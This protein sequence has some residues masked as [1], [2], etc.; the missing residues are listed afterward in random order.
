M[1]TYAEALATV[2]KGVSPLAPR[3]MPAVEAAG[4]VLAQEVVADEDMPAFDRT[5][6]DGYAVRSAD[7]SGRGAQLRCIGEVRTGG[8]ALDRRLESGECAA[9]YTGAPIPPGADAVVMVERTK[10]EGDRVTLEVAVR[11]GE[12]VRFRGEDVKRGERLL[13]SDALLRPQ[14][15]A[16]CTSFGVPTPTVRPRPRVAVLSTGDELVSP[17]AKPGPGQI[18]DS[19]GAMLAT[20]AARAGGEVVSFEV[21]RDERDA[22]R[23]ALDAAAARADVLVLSGGVSMGAYDLVPPVLA[24][25]GFSG[26]FHKV[27]VKPGKPVWFGSRGAVCA[28]GLPGNPVSSFVVFEILV[29]PALR[30]MLGWE[31]GPCF[32]RATVVD[33]PVKGGDREQF[34]PARVEREALSFLPWTSSG[35][36]VELARANALARVPIDVTPRPGETVEFLAI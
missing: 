34:V 14:E 18:R 4:L 15:I 13:A 11:A 9:I 36:L 22:I 3:A 6:M 8:P 30:R 17:D 1:L 24:E 12:N 19:N 25:L 7:A 10:V 16:V 31:P 26:G 28:F 21:V 20:Q 2:L 35:D 5:A 23:A 29:R 33:G 32:E 27:R